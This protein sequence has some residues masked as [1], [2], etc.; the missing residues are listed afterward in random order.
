MVK[1]LGFDPGDVSSSLAASAT[2]EPSVDKTLDD[3]LEAWEK[4]MK[5]KVE[6]E[7]A[8]QRKVVDISEGR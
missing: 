7:K 1:T 4:R 3:R 6:A 5:D 2:S 8:A